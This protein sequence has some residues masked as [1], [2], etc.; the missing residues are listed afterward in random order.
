MRRSKK[1]LENSRQI[2]NHV[3]PRWLF[4]LGVRRGNK[5]AS[6]WSTSC[7]RWCTS[8]AS[9]AKE[10]A[11]LIASSIEFL[12]RSAIYIQKKICVVVVRYW[13]WKVRVLSMEFFAPD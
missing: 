10:I 11:G 2:V 5:C 1:L 12:W 7:D 9:K 6:K 13:N 8:R 4:I 3:L